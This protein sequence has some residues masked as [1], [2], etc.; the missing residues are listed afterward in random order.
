VAAAISTEMGYSSPNQAAAEFIPADVLANPIVYPD[1]ATAAHGEFQDD[2][3]E[4][5]KIYEDYW[6]RLKGSDD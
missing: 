6:V 4:A 2:I 5:M 3:G 1:E